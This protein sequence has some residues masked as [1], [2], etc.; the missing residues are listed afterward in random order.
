M[1]F[2]LVTGFSGQW[3]ILFRNNFTAYKH[4]LL[5]YNLLYRS[6]LLGLP[7]QIYHYALGSD[8]GDQSVQLGKLLLAIT[9]SHSWFQV[10]QNSLPYFI[11]T[12][13][14]APGSMYIALLHTTEKTQSRSSSTA[15]NVKGCSELTSLLG[16]GAWC[17]PAMDTSA[18]FPWF[19]D[20]DI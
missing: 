12:I 10:P 3:I 8:N 9:S 15:V 19:Q 17:H 7:P 4:E 5:F 13:L 6:C 2:R 20:S 1:R 14:L 16:V 11:S 18:T